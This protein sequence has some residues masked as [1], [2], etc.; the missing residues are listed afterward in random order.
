[1][2]TKTIVRRTIPAS[3]AAILVIG[4]TLPATADYTLTFKGTASGGTL[5]LGR[6]WF[7]DTRFVSVDTAPG[8]SLES[9]AQQ[10]T[11]AINAAIDR[12]CGIALSSL[13][14]YSLHWGPA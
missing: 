9:V 2:R 10:L 13:A 12:F 5:I 8:E 7:G 6:I 11:Q 14:E 3:L 4:C 1:M